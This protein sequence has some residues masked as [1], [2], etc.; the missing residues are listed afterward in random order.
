MVC[1][2]FK[3]DKTF[4]GNSREEAISILAALEGLTLD[5]LAPGI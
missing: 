2:G 5:D 3:A 1:K 4:C